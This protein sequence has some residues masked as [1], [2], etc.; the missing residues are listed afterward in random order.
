MLFFIVILLLLVVF[1]IILLY[2]IYSKNEQII[3]EKNLI[4]ISVVIAAKNEAN[5]LNRLVESLKN[6]NYP[7]DKFEVILVDDSSSDQTAHLFK[8]ITNDMSNFRLL[9]AEHK[10]LDGKKGALE[11]GINSAT[12]E[13]IVITDADCILSKNWLINFNYEFKKGNDLIFGAAPFLNEKKFISA[14]QSF[15]NLRNW[16]LIF[17]TYQIG[18]PHS[19]T[20]RSM[21]ITKNLFKSLEGYKHINKTI[22]GDDDLL[23]QLA[24]K[25]NLSISYFLNKDSFAFTYPKK[26]IKEYFYQKSRHTQTSLYYNLKSQLL[27]SIWHLMNLIVFLPPY[28]TLFEPISFIPLGIKL[29]MDII[30]VLTFQKKFN[31]NFSL[32]KIILFQILYEVLIVVNFANVFIL[33]KKWK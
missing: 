18:I 28:F 11:M 24:L 5:N 20:A 15:E 9:S 31:Y 17:F 29:F 16:L 32:I 1:Y 23:L 33:K 8:E 25:K 10:N 6:Q 27:L 22:G 13:N 3:D 12:Y 30:I 26:T 4:S 21:G 14:Y 2:S 19:G 7:P